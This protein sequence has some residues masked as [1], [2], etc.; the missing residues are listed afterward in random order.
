MAQP[1]EWSPEWWAQASHPEYDPVQLK[2]DWSIQLYCGC[3][4]YWSPRGN[5]CC[6][7]PCCFFPLQ[8]CAG[9]CKC[10]LVKTV[11]V[12]DPNVWKP[13]LEKPSDVPDALKGVWWLED[14]IA[15]ERLVCFNDAIWKWKDDD[16][17]T[18]MG[19]WN[20]SLATNW[21][22]DAGCFGHVLTAYTG[23]TG[24]CCLDGFNCSS[25]CK[26]KGGC[27]GN[28]PTKWNHIGIKFNFDS[29]KAYFNNNKSS[30][31]AFQV[32]EDR[33]EKV[34]YNEANATVAPVPPAGTGSKPAY[35]YRWTRVIRGDGSTT[36]HWDDFVKATKTYPHPCFL[37]PCCLW[38]LCHTDTQRR[39]NMA[40]VNRY[41]LVI[42]PWDV[43]GTEF[44]NTGSAPPPQQTM[45]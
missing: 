36:A 35:Y 3:L 43:A 17:N 41:Q 15:G 34:G 33:W 13:A 25:I 42:W 23:I 22:R 6:L 5:C 12:T 31:W 40:M 14:T 45:P 20:K 19:E 21:T 8:L 18:K 39:Q 10:C 26:D 1:A 27:C 2:D 29:G 38:P 16:P 32:S 44:V 7:L 4:D 28:T 11:D 30:E 37:E 24:W 9:Q